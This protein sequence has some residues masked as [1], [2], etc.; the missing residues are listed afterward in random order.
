MSERKVFY[1]TTSN[2]DALQ[3]RLGTRTTR[4]G[5]DEQDALDIEVFTH[6]YDP[7]RANAWLERAKNPLIGGRPAR[8]RMPPPGSVVSTQ[9]AVGMTREW[10]GLPVVM[11]DES[12]ALH[13]VIS[14][15]PPAEQVAVVQQQFGALA[16]GLRAFNLNPKGIR[17][18][19]QVVERVWGYLP[20]DSDLYYDGVSSEF[21]RGRYQASVYGSL[22]PSNWR[23][24]IAANWNSNAR[25]AE[26]YRFGPGEV[27]FGFETDYNYDGIGC[28]VG[29]TSD[30]GDPRLPNNCYAPTGEVHALW[31]QGNAAIRGGKLYTPAQMQAAIQSV[32]STDPYDR[33]FTDPRYGWRGM[34]LEPHLSLVARWRLHAIPPLAWSWAIYFAPQPEFG[35]RTFVDWLLR[36]TPEELIRRVRRDVTRR[37]AETAGRFGLRIVDLVGQAEADAAQARADAARRRAQIETM[38]SAGGQAVGAA[39]SLTP[40]GPL[41][42]LI[43]GGAAQ[44]GIAIARLSSQPRETVGIDVY[45]DLCPAFTQFAITASLTEFDAMVAR[46]VPF[47]PPVDASA[48]PATPASVVGGA[49]VVVP[50]N[51]TMAP[52]GAPG[53]VPVGVAT[54]ANPPPPPGGTTLG[55]INVIPVALPTILS[56]RKMNL[57]LD[58]APNLVVPAAPPPPPPPPT[59]PTPT[60]GNGWKWALALVGL[61]GVGAGGYYVWTRRADAA[62]GASR[63]RAPKR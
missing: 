39:L 6:T 14:A 40:L 48:P 45:G 2:D 18:L 13:V 27:L 53:T 8:E 15:L 21:V 3:A 37:N 43:A 42:G 44:V 4:V 32:R 51:P 1:I 41:G 35:N 23:T 47:P 31:W 7:V 61:G 38:V 9:L 5:Q 36:Q 63:E 33:S 60:S 34:A 58:A 20:A 55:V 46:Q 17:E 26:R 24:R 10:T 59:P 16:N 49:T 52:P 56:A 28:R 54:G 29:G 11:P 62:R 25:N 57:G 19:R 12:D 50:A 22:G 30:D